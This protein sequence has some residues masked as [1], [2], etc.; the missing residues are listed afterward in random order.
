MINIK[1]EINEIDSWQ[2][3]EKNLKGQKLIEKSD[4]VVKPLEWLLQE[5]ERRRK[6]PI[7][8]KKK[9]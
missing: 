4:K 6:I 7:S 9:R 1:A 5:K 3:I 8:E 2:R